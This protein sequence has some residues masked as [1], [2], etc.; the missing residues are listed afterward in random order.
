MC[1]TTTTTTTTMH[2]SSAASSAAAVVVA[3]GGAAAEEEAAERRDGGGGGGGGRDWIEEAIAGC[4]LRRVDLET[5]SNGWASPPGKLF[6]LRPRGYFAPSHR[7]R[8]APSGD[9]LLRPAGVDWLRSPP[10]STTSSPSP[11]LRPRRRRGPPP[12]PPPRP[13]QTPFLLAVNLQVPARP[14]PYSAVFYF[15]SDSPLPPGSLLHRFVRADDDAFRN[16]RF[17]IVNRIVRGPWIVRAAVG[18]HA[19]CLLGRALTCRYHRG[20]GYL[21][22]DV[23]IGSSALASAVLHLALGSAAAVA[24]DMGFVVEAQTDDEL[25]ER[26]IGAVRIA[27]ID[28]ASAYY[29]D[30]KATATGS[31]SESE[32]SELEAGKGGGCWGPAKVNHHSH[33]H[34]HHHHRSPEAPAPAPPKDRDG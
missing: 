14:D 27:H 18:N 3:V 26:L 21:E 22:I 19:A 2:A 31:E 25:P 6:M 4:S 29:L 24:I 33:H 23:D 16:A 12:R 15:A 7:R 28:M 13:L 10:A 32:E 1:P 5:G 34:H 20:D 11:G 9:W 17:K 8:K 30:P